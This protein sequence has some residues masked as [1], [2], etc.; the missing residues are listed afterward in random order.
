[1][2]DKQCSIVEVEEEETSEYYECVMTPIN[3][4]VDK[5][6]GFTF[7]GS[8]AEYLKGHEVIMEMIQKKGDRF[9]INGIEIAVVDNQENKPVPI[10]VKP[11]NG[12]SG[13][14]N[15]KV[16]AVNKGGGATI[17]VTKIRGGD[18]I[19]VKA[20][21]YNVVKYILD[22]MISR[23][24]TSGDIKGMRKKITIKA[25]KKKGGI[26]YDLCENKF[27]S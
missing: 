7:K 6:T 8:D 14:A 27:V 5:K 25:G 4:P 17:M 24:I 22:S 19:H 15:L 26:A 1:M 12:L 2:K 13:K 9:E 10:E 21:A 11:K 18:M 16:Y 20:L 23:E 3:S